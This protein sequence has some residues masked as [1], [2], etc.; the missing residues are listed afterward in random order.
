MAFKDTALGRIG[1]CRIDISFE[2]HLYHIRYSPRL[3]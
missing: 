3:L 1:D 2:S